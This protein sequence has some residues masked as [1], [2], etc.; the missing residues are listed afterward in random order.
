[1]GE[2]RRAVVVGGARDL[3]QVLRF[4]PSNYDAAE[5]GGRIVIEGRDSAGWTLEGYVLP[6]LASGGIW[7]R[8]ER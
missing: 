5:I 8:E 7:A 6:R 3:Q 2:L 4:L 1:M